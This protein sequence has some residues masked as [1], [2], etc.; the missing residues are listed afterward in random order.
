MK[1]E[2]NILYIDDTPYHTNIPDDNHVKKTRKNLNPNEIRA[3][4]PGTVIE[5]KVNKGDRVSQGQVILILEAMKMY[6]ELEAG[7]DGSIE[8][9]YISSGEKVEKDRLMVKIGKI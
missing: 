7:I 8:E 4:I 6:N 1:E 2:L 3:N 9:I 5:V